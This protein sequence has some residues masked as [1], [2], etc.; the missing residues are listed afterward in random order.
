MELHPVLAGMVE[1]ASR[2]KRMNEAP[3]AAVRGA[4]AKLLDTGL[5]PKRSARS[6]IS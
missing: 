2:H 5:P 6:R 4:A 3:L 1:K